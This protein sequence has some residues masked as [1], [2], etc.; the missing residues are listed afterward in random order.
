MTEPPPNAILMWSDGAKLYALLP[1]TTGGYYPMAF[2]LIEDGLARALALLKT[3]PKPG[4][5][6]VAYA[7][8]KSKTFTPSQYAA[9]EGVLKRMKR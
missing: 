8:R 1:L 6:T 3:P 9:A 7:P 5:H 2:S 4:R